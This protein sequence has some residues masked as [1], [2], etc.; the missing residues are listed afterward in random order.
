MSADTAVPIW[1][2][3]LSESVERMDQSELAQ[4][5][6]KKLREYIAAYNLNSFGMVEKDELCSLI[7]RSRFTDHNESHFRALVPQPFN[8]N[9][10]SSSRQRE[11]TSEPD[12][13]RWRPGNQTSSSVPANEPTSNSDQSILQELGNMFS[14]SG[15]NNEIQNALHDIPDMISGIFGNSRDG[16]QQSSVPVNSTAQTAADTL[17]TTPPIIPSNTD[18]MRYSSSPV[19]STAS[20]SVPHNFEEPANSDRMRQNSSPAQQSYPSTGS[21][22]PTG[23]SRNVSPNTWPNLETIIANNINLESLS[24]RA[25]KDILWTHHVEFSVLEKGELIILVQRLIDNQKYEKH[26]PQNEDV[27]CKVFLVNPDLF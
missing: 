24:V 4:L 3:T 2:V 1:L 23:N 12:T 16:T 6:A 20:T 8:Y 7:I 9:I 14:G 13:K 18:R 5:P 15:I 26:E 10:P 17:S 21:Y 25:L 27:L 11:T 22:P 19:Q